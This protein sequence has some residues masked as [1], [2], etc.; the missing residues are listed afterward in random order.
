M[1]VDGTV[2]SAPQ[3]GWITDLVARHIELAGDPDKQ[4][5]VWMQEGAPLGLNR[6]ITDGKI[7]PRVEPQNIDKE[8]MDGHFHQE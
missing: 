3:C 2:V 4:L 8:Y 7:F 1:R 5:V 6:P